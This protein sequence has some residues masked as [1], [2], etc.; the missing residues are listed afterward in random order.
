MIFHLVQTRIFFSGAT[1][2]FRTA[3]CVSFPVEVLFFFPQKV[4]TFHAKAGL[5]S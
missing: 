3:V 2:N 4:E 1:Q 5:E